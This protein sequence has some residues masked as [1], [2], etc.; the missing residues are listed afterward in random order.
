MTYSCGGR[1]CR[2]RCWE[3]RSPPCQRV[4]RHPTRRRRTPYLAWRGEHV[5]L[6]KCDAVD[7]RRRARRG[8]ARRGLERRRS[9]RR[10]RP[11]VAGSVKFFFD[12]GARRE[13]RARHLV[14]VKAG[15]AP[16]KLVDQR[17]GRRPGADAPVPGGLAEPDARRRSTR[18]RRRQTGDPWL[19]DPAGDGQFAPAA[20]A[21]RIQV[22]VKGTLPLL[23]NY[24]ELGLGAP[25]TLPDGWTALAHALATDADALNR[26]PGTAGTSTT[27]TCSTRFAACDGVDGGRATRPVLPKVF[28]DMSTTRPTA[29]STR[30]GPAR[31]SSP[32]ASSTRVTRRCRPRASTSRSPRTAA[33][34]ADISGVGSLGPSQAARL[35]PR[36]APARRPITTCSRRSTPSTSPPRPAGPSA[37]GIDGGPA[38]NFNGFLVNG[39]YTNWDVAATVAHR[40]DGN[41]NCL[42]RR[43]PRLNVEV[44]S[45][46]K[47][48]R[49]LPRGAQNVVVYTD[50][51]GEAQVAYTPGT[52]MYFD[53]LG[54]IMNDNG[55]CDLQGIDVLGTVGHQRHGPVS[56]PARHGSGQ[57]V[58]PRS[59]RP[60]T[61]SSTKKLSYCPKGPGPENDVARIVV[62][63]ARNITGVGFGHERV[64]FMA[65]LPDRGHEGVHRRDRSRQRPHLPGRHGQGR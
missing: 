3:R 60:C 5:R 53:N 54:A 36:P 22:K 6:V 64:C 15:I 33:L 35:Q 37:S 1:R 23:G 50:E 65:G 57:G 30:S 7:P 56:V 43:E 18:S 61:T 28:G 59:R 32:T 38:N 21:G 8:R 46:G 44:V 26:T 31:R 16:I 24:A 34:P 39:L 17:C 10:C 63:H 13:L 9:G 41:T 12:E 42:L 14:S 47:T 4:R 40:L 20:R 27:T 19:G 48:F 45:W 55:G 58:P 2:S 49:Q 52:G 62:A 51:H 29:R 25:I 11:V